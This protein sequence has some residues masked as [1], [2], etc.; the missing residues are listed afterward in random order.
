[1]QRDIG[2]DDIKRAKDAAALQQIVYP[3]AIKDDQVERRLKMIAEN[4]KL[5]ASWPI[6]N[7]R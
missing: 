6:V 7:G 4:V 3:P 1:M 5:T 2:F